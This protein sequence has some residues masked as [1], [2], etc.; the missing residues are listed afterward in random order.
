MNDILEIFQKAFHAICNFLPKSQE[1]VDNGYN[2]MGNSS[3]HDKG[4]QTEETSHNVSELEGHTQP[5]K[6]EEVF[7]PTIRTE[8]NEYGKPLVQFR[9]YRANNRKF[10]EKLGVS[11]LDRLRIAD[12]VKILERLSPTEHCLNLCQNVSFLTDGFVCEYLPYM[13][14]T[15]IAKGGSFDQDS[16]MCLW[17][18]VATALDYCHKHDILHRDVAPA[19]IGLRYNLPLRDTL[20]VVL[21]DFDMAVIGTRTADGML[22][23][24]KSIGRFDYCP[25]V[26]HEYNKRCNY[27]EAHD[28]ESLVYVYICTQKG[29]L[30]WDY[31]T[32][33]DDELFYFKRAALIT[34]QQ[35]R[36]YPLCG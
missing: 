11:E 25:Y 12:E 6:A 33:S 32:N 34:M 23:S 26:F 27:L 10:F 2:K 1:N 8:R 16:L 30:P 5:R 22:M 20:C 28:F 24:K 29:H 7:E 4:Q 14:D 31:E 36:Q 19:N 9:V 18:G 3:T 21:F 15:V 35:D 17:E 13:L